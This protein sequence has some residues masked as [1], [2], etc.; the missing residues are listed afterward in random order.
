MNVTP[1]STT[2]KTAAPP[3]PKC[4]FH[5]IRQI[6]SIRDGEGALWAG[7]QQTVR[8]NVDRGFI[9]PT[10]VIE[11]AGSDYSFTPEWPITTNDVGESVLPPELIAGP[12]GEVVEPAILY[13]DWDDGGV[14]VGLSV[15][16][17]EHLA[18]YVRTIKGDGVVCCIGGHGRTGTVLSILAA[19]LGLVPQEE[20][21]V[22][23]VRD[24]YCPDAVETN[25]QIMYIERMTGCKVHA[26]PSDNWWSSG[27]DAYKPAKT[28][29]TVRELFEG[30][31]DDHDE[32]ARMNGY[33]S[34]YGSSSGIYNHKDDNG[35]HQQ[36]ED[37]WADNA[38]MRRG[39]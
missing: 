27:Y 38:D 14:P 11:L 33:G 8:A 36:I 39:A 1:N 18:K 19:K 25:G 2:T 29:P 21:P 28:G 37:Q 3:P 23:W 16:W 7:A 15:A 20:D 32:V 5:P 34:S 35:V 4:R 26:R 24:H 17:W 6:F 13:I 31:D 12:T 22:A 10:F 9:T 30:P